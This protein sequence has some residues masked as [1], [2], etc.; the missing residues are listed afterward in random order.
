MRKNSLIAMLMIATFIF[1]KGKYKGPYL[2]LD[3]NR[4]IV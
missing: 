4:K 2:A 3:Q 1:N